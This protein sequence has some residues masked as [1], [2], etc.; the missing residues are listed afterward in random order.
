VWVGTFIGA[1]LDEWLPRTYLQLR[2][3][4]AF[5][6]RVAGVKH[7][8]INADAEIGY[9]LSPKWS[10]RLIGNWQDTDGGINVPIALDDELF[11]HHDQLAAT[12]YFNMGGGIAWAPTEHVRT[13][14][15]YGTA[16]HGRNAH[17]MDDSF[18]FGVSYGGMR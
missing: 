18:T 7:D 13:Y 1:S 4:Y 9:F 5:V 15:L 12:R 17:M 11:E 2:L 6:E 3:N 16:L 8:R 10:V 14:L